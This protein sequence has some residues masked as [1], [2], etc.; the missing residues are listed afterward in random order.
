MHGISYICISKTKRR[1]MARNG[2]V[3][4]KQI[5]RFFI[6]IVGFVICAI[7]VESY[8]SIPKYCYGL[9][10]KE[11]VLRLCLQ[12]CKSRYRNNPKKKKDCIKRCNAKYG[13]PVE[14]Y[15]NGM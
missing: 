10:N 4:Y 14:S 12:R 8:D 5:T 2:G 1:H 15:N 3:T 7:I 13:P 11:Y 9:E 6:I